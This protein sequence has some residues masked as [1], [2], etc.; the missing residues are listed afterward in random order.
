MP[1]PQNT[2]LTPDKSS[3]LT[4]EVKRQI[5][6]LSDSLKNKKYGDAAYILLSNTK[7]KLQATLDALLSKKGIITPQQTNA[8][9]DQI[10]QAKKARLE[11][12]Y[13]TGMSKTLMVGLGVLLISVGAYY[14][15]KSKKK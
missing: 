11:Q 5:Q 10:N 2:A 9:L 7:D 6:L 3:V 12:D 4:D 8:T 1:V 15:F 14:Y 13:S